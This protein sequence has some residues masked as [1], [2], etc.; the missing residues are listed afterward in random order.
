MLDQTK[1]SRLP[2]K[3]GIVTLNFA[4]SPFN[5]LKMFRTNPKTMSI[6]ISISEE[7]LLL[8]FY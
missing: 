4:Y 7:H 2:N 3:L 1:L 6:S 5:S 8:G